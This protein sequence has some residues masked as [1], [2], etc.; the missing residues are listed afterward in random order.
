MTDAWKN[1][2]AGSSEITAALIGSGI[3]L[4][5]TPGMHER[6]GHVL[7]LNYSYE[8]MDV[9][10]A[11]YC[12]FSLAQLI[13]R[14]ESLGYAGLNITYP[15]KQEVLPLLDEL[16]VNAKMLAAVNTVV[17]KQGRRFGYNTDYSG[18]VKAFEQQM[19]DVV[20]DRV[21]LLGAGGA[22]SAA[23]FAMAGSSPKSVFIYDCNPEKAA[24]LALKLNIY[25]PHLN[26]ECYDCLTKAIAAKPNGV[27]NSSPMGMQAY[28]GSAFP[29]GE[30]QPFQWAAD[31]VYL[32]LQTQFLC[33]AEAAGCK[34]MSGAHLAIQ[35][36]VDSFA[37]ITGQLADAQHFSR[38]FAALN[39]H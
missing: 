16:S 9:D 25:Y 27:I 19:S 4:S 1:S 22:G 39:K 18:F 34:T 28:P 38:A 8:I 30:W 2:R 20:V 7:G 11:Q 14:C 32:P 17:F 37:I 6:V 12:N 10:T 26:V 5:R 15:F 13:E 21:L 35:Q 3:G 33:D 23:A 29:Q 31:L 36:A 24:Q